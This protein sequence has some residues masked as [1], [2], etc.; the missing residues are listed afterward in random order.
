MNYWPRQIER[1]FFPKRR[2]QNASVLKTPSFLEREGGVYFFP[3]SELH[4]QEGQIRKN[5]RVGDKWN[6]KKREQ[7]TDENPFELW[8]PKSFFSSF[9]EA[10]AEKGR[11]SSSRE[12]SFHIDTSRSS[13]KARLKGL[14][15]VVK[16]VH[17]KIVAVPESQF[18]E[19]RGKGAS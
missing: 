11:V 13:A 16:G 9:P 18:I 3:K 7:T 17:E 4:N 14:N 15:P 8:G 6:L 5:L 1:R 10:F 12:N 2:K 19:L